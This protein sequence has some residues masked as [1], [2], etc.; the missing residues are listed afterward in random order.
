MGLL[1]SVKN[2]AST[3]AGNIKSQGL[4]N[5]KGNLKDS[6]GD[7]ARGIL[8]V[9]STNYDKNP[10]AKKAQENLLKAA[11]NKL[12]KLSATSSSSVVRYEDVLKDNLLSGTGYLALGVQYNPSTIHFTTTTGG[13]R[14]RYGREHMG[15]LGD[16]QMSEYK[17]YK[18]THMRFTLIFEDV[19]L[20]DAFRSPYDTLVS[21][22][23]G[24]VLSAAKTAGSLV[25]SGYNWLTG[26]N[27]GKDSKV[28]SD[29]VH[30]IRTYMD[31]IM[32]LLVSQQTRDVIFYWGT[33]CFHG[34]LVGVDSQY[35]MFNA[36]GE[37]VF[38]EITLELMQSERTGTEETFK[39]EQQRWKDSFDALFTEESETLQKLQEDNEEE[40]V[41]ELSVDEITKLGVSMTA[42]EGKMMTNALSGV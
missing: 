42:S 6:T 33:M 23:A 15:G 17:Q 27:Q 8:C 4:D 32:G 9:K 19:V 37:P 21:G 18:S 25:S 24:S 28:S 1:D 3:E 11:Q 39:Y 35:K 16:N 26:K 38:G 7:I 36:K 29:K 40:D 12:G 20:G 14:R 41:E 30:S 10:D 31:G 13:I 2:F 5:L 22:S 34:T